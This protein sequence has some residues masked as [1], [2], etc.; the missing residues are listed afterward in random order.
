M[1]NLTLLCLAGLAVL[2]VGC[3]GS[4][5]Q[6]SPPPAPAAPAAQED[7]ATPAAKAAPEIEAAYWLN[8]DPLTL[9]GLRGKIVVLEFWATWC[10]PCRQTIPHLVALHKKTAER[11][12]VIVSLT[13]EPRQEVEPFAKELAM[14]YAIGGGSKSGATYGVQGI[15]HA[16]IIDPSGAIV[17]EGHPMAGMAEVLEL[18]LK[19][20]PPLA[21]GA[22]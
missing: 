14:T 6:P 17:W 12:V 1:R 20:T 5:P 18:Q 7:P 13:D 3:N 22:K 11:G 15:P 19:K 8:S 10:P 9:Q 4:A 16:F 2:V 21:G